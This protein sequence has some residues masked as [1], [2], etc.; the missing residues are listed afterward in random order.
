MSAPKPPVRRVGLGSAPLGNLYEAITDEASSAVVD[1]AWQAGIRTFDTAP[2]Y[3]I[4]LAET[5][6]GAALA[7]RPRDEF[8]VSTKVGRVLVPTPERA[9]ELDEHGFVTPAVYRREWDF[10]RDGILRSI[11]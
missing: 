8:S 6:L 1:D 7:D 4:G 5:R 9:G 10:S 3:G 11:D 2:H